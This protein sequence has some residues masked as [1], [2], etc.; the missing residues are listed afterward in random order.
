MGERAYPKYSPRLHLQNAIRA[1]LLNY[2]LVSLRRD[3]EC[4][5]T[6]M[7]AGWA[8]DTYRGTEISSAVLKWF[9]TIS[10]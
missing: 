6:R 1:C 5:R 4:G 2:E 10:G 7:T 8:L 3:R 9:S